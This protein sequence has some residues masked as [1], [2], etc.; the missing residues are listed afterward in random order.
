MTKPSTSTQ[1]YQPLSGPDSRPLARCVRGDATAH[2]GSSLL[3]LNTFWNPCTVPTVSQYVFLE[4]TRHRACEQDQ[5]LYHP[6][7]IGDV[8]SRVQ[9]FWTLQLVL[10][11]RAELAVSTYGDHPFHACA[12]TNLP[13]I[14]DCVDMES[15]SV[16]HQ[17]L[18]AAACLE[19][20][21]SAGD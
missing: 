11:I 12:V 18:Y 9:L 1:N 17:G 21:L 4:S 8:Q 16:S 19:R 13:D 6:Q 10:A 3:I 7:S 2:N 14:S 20:G 5:L 15:A